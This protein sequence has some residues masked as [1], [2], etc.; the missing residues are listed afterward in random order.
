MLY[1][2]LARRFAETMLYWRR[3]LRAREVQ[4]FLGVSERTARSLI[5]GWRI[6]GIL[7]PYRAA[8]ARYLVPSPGFKP[9]A[10]VTDPNVALSLLLVADRLPG[11]P[12][13]PVA[14]PGGGHDLALSAPIASRAIR[15]VVAACLDRAP[16]WLLYAAKTGRQEFV[17]HPSA[18]IRGRG[19]YHLRGFRSD[20]QD[21]AGS[22]LDDRFVDV[23]PARAIEARPTE[24]AT[25]VG[26]DE[27]VEWHISE[28]REFVLS[29]ALTD[30]ERLC[31]E[32]EYGIADSGILKVTQRR[33]LIP[34]V[35]QELS[36]RRCW[37]TDG[38]SV[39]VWRTV[40]AC[41][42][43]VCADGAASRRSNQKQG[44]PPTAPLE[45]P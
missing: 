19:R 7:P 8:D 16:V 25:F 5:R 42:A 33:A 24:D 12:F 13:S 43:V 39:A 9:S 35:L 2:K 26:L 30:H 20:G 14:P 10:A 45:N 29:P 40:S 15:S 41:N 32:H 28:T 21:R 17:F 44:A 18:L 27:D 36:E 3:H 4:A 31:Y 34:F 1:E 22:R 11:N 6:E 23:V 38:S 37:R